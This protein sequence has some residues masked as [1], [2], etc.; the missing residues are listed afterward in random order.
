[1]ATNPSLWILLVVALLILLP[2]IA[3]HL[4]LRKLRQQG[5]YPETG[6]ASMDDVD[7]LLERGDT[8]LA[9]RCYREIHRCDLRQAKAAIEAMIAPK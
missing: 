8:V 6:T 3:F 4:K 5:Q 2:S 7:R 1:M 9:I